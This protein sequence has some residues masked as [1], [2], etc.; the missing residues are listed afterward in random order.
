MA[1]GC[2]TS[3]RPN[4]VKTFS[5]VRISWD[6]LAL[7]MQTPIF[8]DRQNPK[9]QVAFSQPITRCPSRRNLAQARGCPLKTPSLDKSSS[10]NVARA[11]K[12]SLR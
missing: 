9:R 11:P 8:Y 3:F 4:Q 7:G 1:S 5:K 6:N 2:V 10:R 12:A